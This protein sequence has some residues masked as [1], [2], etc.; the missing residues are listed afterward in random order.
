MGDKLDN[1]IKAIDLADRIPGCNV[2]TRSPFYRTEPVGVEGQDWYINGV[3]SVSTDNPAR[4]L[5][6]SLLLIEANM[7]RERKEKWDPRPIDLDILL[8]D[9]D[10]IEEEDLTIPHPL[11]HLRK[12]VLAP[13][14][15]LAPDLS[16][17]VLGKTMVKLLD[18]VSNKGQAVTRV[19]EA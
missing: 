10:V 3:F 15:D 9:R 5:L 12:F 2:E 17:P 16:H 8:F 7:G 13:M 14:V 19:V 1:C 6:Q 11:M 4:D 18:Q